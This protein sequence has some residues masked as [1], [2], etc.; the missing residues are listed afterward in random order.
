MELVAKKNRVTIEN[1]QAKLIKYKNRMR[2]PISSMEI[3]R[4]GKRTCTLSMKP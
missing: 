4:R 2:R 1:L 3:C